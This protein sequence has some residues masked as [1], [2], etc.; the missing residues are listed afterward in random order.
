MLFVYRLDDLPCC[1]LLNGYQK[2]FIDLPNGVLSTGNTSTRIAESNTASGTET[3]THFLF[4]LLWDS[5]QT[6]ESTVVVY[7]GISSALSTVV[8]TVI[9]VLPLACA[10]PCATWG[11][12]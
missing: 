3:L 4:S 5:F 12:K 2:V 7:S 9:C 8:L 11:A 10:R 6:R 1:V